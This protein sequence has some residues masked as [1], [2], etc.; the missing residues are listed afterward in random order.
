[1]D[2]PSRGMLGWVGIFRLAL[3]Q[4]ALGSIVVLTTSVVMPAVAA[5]GAVLLFALIALQVLWYLHWLPP[6]GAA[7]TLVWLDAFT[8]NVDRTWRNPN[9]LWWHGRMWA[10]DHG[11]SLYFHHSW[12]AGVGDPARFAAQAWDGSDHVFAAVLPGVA[13]VDAELRSRLSGEVFAQLLDEVPDAWL[14]PVPG[15]PSATALRAA[16]VS[17]LEARLRSD[18]WLPKEAS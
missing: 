11:A 15:A 1:M 17:F 16:Y 2:T 12:D 13:G 3:V 14:T 7:A 4:M 9:L 8:A 6:E 18:A 10:I 5:V